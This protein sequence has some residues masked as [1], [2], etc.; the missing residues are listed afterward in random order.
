[1]AIVLVSP[2]LGE[3]P[4]GDQLREAHVLGEGEDPMRRRA[5][6][7]GIRGGRSGEGDCIDRSSRKPEQMGG[8]KHGGGY[9]RNKA[10]IDQRMNERY[11]ET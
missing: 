5:H 10:T 1:M 8:W 7:S 2:H 6:R 9:Q 11:C 4:S 3:G